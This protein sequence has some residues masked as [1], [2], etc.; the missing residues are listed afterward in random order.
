MPN[1]LVFNGTAEQL[2]TQISGV[3]EAGNSTKILTDSSGSLVI[4]TVTVT[5]ENFDVRPL[6]GTTDS[7]TVF[8]T[9]TVT[10]ENFDV[11]PLSGTTDSVTVFGTVTVTAENFDV[12]PLSGTT[13]SVT[14]FGTVTVTAENFDIRNLS[15]VT[16]SIQI[17]SRLFTESNTT[18]RGVADSALVFIQNNEAQ[19]EYTF[20]VF[21]S[22]NNTLTVQLQISPT[23]T[24]SYF[25][26]D[27]GGPV[28]IARGSKATLI[29][30]RFLKYTGLFYETSGVTCTFEA[31]YNAQV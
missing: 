17:S 22:G 10:A 6:S 8:G 4:G 25:V 27:P 21:N 16:D 31:F 7:V 15:G 2:Q 9:V 1:Y 30:S 28:G 29:A 20:Y 23:T 18:I 11:R 5:A 3:D 14:V 19:S 12:R 13:D 24:T 26:N